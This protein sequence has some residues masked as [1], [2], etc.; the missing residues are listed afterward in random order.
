MGC[1]AH[2][3]CLYQCGL[4][5]QNS[6]ILFSSVFVVLFGLLQILFSGVTPSGSQRTCRCFEPG[7]GR[8]SSLKASSGSSQLCSLGNAA[9][10]PLPSSGLGLGALSGLQK[11]PYPELFPSSDIDP[12]LLTQSEVFLRASTAG[13]GRQHSAQGTR[14]VCRRP[15]FN[16]QH[17]MSHKHYQ[18]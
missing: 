16:S 7:C 15:G 13:L 1:G 8:A 12:T 3:V 18:E 5:G 6:T 9:S 2:K 4:I 11:K 10:S 14:L 17:T